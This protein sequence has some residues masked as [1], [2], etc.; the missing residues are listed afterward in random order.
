MILIS[1]SPNHADTCMTGYDL[2]QETTEPHRTEIRILGHSGFGGSRYFP[3]E[4]L[5][6]TWELNQVS[7]L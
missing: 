7:W 4:V 2:H 3:C 1:V 5:W 6:A